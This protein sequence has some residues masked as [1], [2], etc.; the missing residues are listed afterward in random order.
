[1]I[2]LLDRYRE[3]ADGGRQFHGLSILTHK[4]EIGKLISETGAKTLLDFGCGRGDAYRSPHKLHHQWGIS[5]KNVTLYD[6]S[7]KQ[8]A[9]RPVGRSDIV[10]CSDVLEHIPEEGVDRFVADLFNH[11]KLAV[12]ASVC[13]RPARKCFPGTDINL[14]CTV[15]P[16]QWWHD[17]FSG[18]APLFHALGTRWELVE[19]P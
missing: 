8:Y 16:Y 3:M 7:F 17:T 15:K 9:G 18:I 1:M 5:R 19:T 12:W 10:V 6:P 14:H 13:T 2:D 4:D 11:A